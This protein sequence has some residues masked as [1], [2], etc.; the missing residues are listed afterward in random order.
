MKTKRSKALFKVF[1]WLAVPTAVATILIVLTNN[2]DWRAAALAFVACA[3]GVYLRTLYNNDW[4]ED[5][6]SQN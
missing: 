3:C 1:M 2:Y 4:E 6:E 5:D